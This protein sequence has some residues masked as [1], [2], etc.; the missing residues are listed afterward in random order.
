[1][2]EQ[3]VVTM[4]RLL[5]LE[6]KVT[7]IESQIEMLDRIAHASADLAREVRALAGSIDQVSLRNAELKA[8][9]DELL[10]HQKEKG[11]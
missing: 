1:M 5:I 8:K 10:R 4:R 3:E 11:Q 2:T 6:Q 9:L 7:V